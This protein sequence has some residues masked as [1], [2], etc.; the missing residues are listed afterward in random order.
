MS[1]ARVGRQSDETHALALRKD[2]QAPCTQSAPA[3]PA[4]AEIYFPQE[5]GEFLGHL[6]KSPSAASDLVKVKM[7]DWIDQS[8]HPQPPV[9][10]INVPVRR[11]DRGTFARFHH[12]DLSGQIVDD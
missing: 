12:A 9:A 3:F 8:T 10:P 7:C 1:R 2:G 4:R 6:R 5:R 11:D